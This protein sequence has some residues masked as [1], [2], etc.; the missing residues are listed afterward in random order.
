MPLGSHV[1]PHARTRPAKH[2]WLPLG[3]LA[4][5]L[6]VTAGSSAALARTQDSTAAA[7]SSSTARSIRDAA[8]Q[9]I[10]TTTRAT[11][12]AQTS[13]ALSRTSQTF[14]RTYRTHRTS[15]D[16]PPWAGG[17]Y[18]WWGQRITLW[19]DDAC[20]DTTDDESQEPTP[21]DPE[22]TEPAPSTPAPSGG[23]A[24]AGST[25]VPAGTSLTASKGDLSITKD[26][27]VVEGKD[28]SGTVWIDADD[29][30]IRSSRITGKGFAVVQVKNGST[31]VSIEN[32]EIDGLGAQAG[33][34]GVIGPADVSGS[35]VRGVENGLTP[36]SGSVLKGNYVHD[37]KA[38]GSPHYDGVQIDGGL[39]GIT[40]SGNYVDLHEHTQ[41]SAVMIDNY[42]GPIS[43]IRVDGNR[44]VG[45]GYTVYSDGQFTGGSITGVSFT[46]NR[47]G[48]GYYGYASI[49]KNSP[50]WSGNVDDVTGKSAR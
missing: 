6:A 17:L 16:C 30:T 29:V 32:V 8:E 26:G 42:F 37:L 5:V 28:I 12:S 21:A 24:T 36:G 31:N 7:E 19:D 44:L 18:T 22:P 27:T 20:D 41:T 14:P 43:N 3:L 23:I 46:N 10:A 34:M 40:L 49:V 2:R 15:S 48:K 11:S 47:L 50:V 1:D 39:S 35:D 38:P 45:G 4:A 33:S 13:R 9:T 25:G